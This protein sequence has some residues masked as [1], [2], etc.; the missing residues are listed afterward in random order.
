MNITKARVRRT[1]ETQSQKGIKKMIYIVFLNSENSVI[2]VSSWS[3]MKLKRND[4]HE[5]TK[6]R[7]GKINAI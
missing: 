1:R 4:Y 2:F 3:K 6:T 7:K 5:S